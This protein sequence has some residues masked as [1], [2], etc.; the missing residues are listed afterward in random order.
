MAKVSELTDQE[1][2]NYINAYEKKVA[3][4]DEL[5]KNTKVLT[6]L[7][8]ELHKRNGSEVSDEPVVVHH[9]SDV[10]YNNYEEAGFGARAIAFFI[11]GIL[12][13]ICNQILVLG[14]MAIVKSSLPSNFKVLSTIIPIFVMVG[15]PIAYV[16]F[17]L[18]KNGQTIGK[19]I[20][21]IK[22]IDEKG[23][24]QLDAK[25]ILKREALGKFIS[26]VVFYIGFIVTLF[27]KKAWH[28]SLADT[29][30]VKLK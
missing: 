2:S 27:G 19:K 11:D 13:G 17:F 29:K 9:S 16:I 6:S 15:L 21:K 1:L 20:M 18:R 23:S 3:N 7:K 10:N 26:A 14:I 4:G 5:E 30:V 24:D 25:T 12:L 22:I 28:D 8:N